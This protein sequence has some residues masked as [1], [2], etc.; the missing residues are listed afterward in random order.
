MEPL[1]RLSA[2]D[3]TNLAVEAA[4]TPMHQAVLATIERAALVDAQGNVRIAE[5]RDHVAARLSRVPELRRVLYRPPLFFGSPLWI[6]DRDFRIEDHVLLASL[7]APGGESGAIAFAEQQMATLMDRSRPLWKIWILDGYSPDRLGLLIKLHH[8]VADGPAMVNMLGQILDIEP[9]SMDAAGAPLSPGNP[10]SAGR[11]LADNIARKSAWLWRTITGATHPRRS[12]RQ[13]RTLFAGGAEAIR[14]GLGAQLRPLNRPIGRTRR[15][16]AFRV[17][18]DEA[19]RVAH[20]FG[21]KL[22]D[23][24]FYAVASGCRRRL[25]ASGQPLAGIRLRLSMA[26][27]GSPVNVTSGNHAGTMIVSVPID[28]DDP[29]ELLMAVASATAAAKV[30]QMPIVSTG[31]M[32]FLARIGF[33]RL[34]IRHQRMLNVLTTNLPGPPV[35]LYFAGGRIWSPIALPPIAGN[36]TLSFA[37]L[38]YGHE[39]SLSVIADGATWPDL[40]PLISSMQSSWHQLGE[41]ATASGRLSA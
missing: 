36:V 1:V 35:P 15:I 3:L 23:V 12:L 30:K 34:F 26:V 29:T 13:L 38:S 25:T 39:L 16:A 28:I 10:P 22:N 19:K 31:L 17:S 40:D 41:I 6:D 37:A 2:A 24:F 14:Q 20:H 8:S 33:T 9:G 32:V 18:L 5:L 27:S 4:D 21:V 11:L 7:P